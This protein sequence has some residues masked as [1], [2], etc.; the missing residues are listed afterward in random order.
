M[1]RGSL[2]V[3]LALAMK[4][5]GP[6]PEEQALRILHLVHQDVAWSAASRVAQDLTGD[7]VPEIALPGSSP[8]KLAIGIIVGPVGPLS[9]MMVLSWSVELLGGVA[10]ASHMTLEVEDPHLPADLWG[11][12]ATDM[13]TFCEDNRTLAAALRAASARGTK[14]VSFR[15]PGCPSVHAY[16]DART[17]NLGWWRDLSASSLTE[18]RPVVLQS[19]R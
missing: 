11:C 3:L 2:V 18:V 12:A 16:W 17:E 1:T 8:N 7:G 13:S 15:A 4:P 9:K 19:P 14:A 5:R 10:C 6:T